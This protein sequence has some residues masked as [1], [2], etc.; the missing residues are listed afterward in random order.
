M[1]KFL[2]LTAVLLSGAASFISA[3]PLVLE[4]AG[5]TI[6]ANV[7]EL[8]LTDIN[9]RHDYTIFVD[10]AG[11]ELSK[12]T[13]SSLSAPLFCSY[14]VTDRIEA[15]LQMP[16]VS[17]ATKSE[18][19]GSSSTDSKAY[20]A[21]QVIGGKISLLDGD[22]KFGAGLSL[23]LPFGEKKYRAG[24]DIT[25][26]MAL[27]RDLGAAVVNANLSYD[28]TAEYTDDSSQVKLN[29]GDVLSL[30]IGAEFACK[31][32]ESVSLLAEFL[33][34]SIGQ[35]S[36]A[37]TAQS[38]SSGSRMELDLGARYNRGSLKT[39]FGF[40]LSLGEEKFRSYDYRIIAGLTYLVNI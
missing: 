20:L 27:S 5:S 17:A 14:G 29:P 25:P 3:E 36:I 38:G 35:S 34:S 22:Y 33:Y 2:A 11:N 10:D 28:L 12:L 9:Y 37:G 8:G 19:G 31:K 24:Y 13:S 32:I 23:A 18:A 6:G 4:K 7:I 15:F 39:K 26:L 30:G 1:K 40:G 16:Y 21:D